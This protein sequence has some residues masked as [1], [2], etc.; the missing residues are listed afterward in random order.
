MSHKIC[1]VEVLVLDTHHG[2]V[3]KAIEDAI[4]PYA[5]EGAALL[6]AHDPRRDRGRDCLTHAEVGRLGR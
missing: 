6:T 4:R 5:N 2:A 3:R 1:L